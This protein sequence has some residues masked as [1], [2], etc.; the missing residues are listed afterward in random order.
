MAESNNRTTLIAG[1]FVLCGVVLL[2]GLIMEYGPLQHWMRKPYSVHAVFSDAQGLIKGAPVRLRGS[3]IGKVSTAP[4]L[5]SGLKGVQVSLDIYPEFKIPRNSQLKITTVGL[6]GDC[7]VDVVPPPP[8]KLTGEF[9][10][11]G[12]TLDGVGSTDLTAVATK[13]TD[14]ATEVMKDI[15][16]SLAE[17]NK[18]I[19]RIN[20]GVLSDANFKH[21]SDSLASLNRIIEK[22]ETTV[23][24][25]E[26]VAAVRDSLAA[27]KTT[28]QNA[29]ASSA[30]VRTAAEKIDKAMDQIGPGMKGFAGATAALHD[31][32]NALEAL[33]KEARSGRGLLYAL[34]NDSYLRD[35]LQRL[36]ANLRQRGILFYKDKEPPAAVAPAPVPAKRSPA[37]SSR[38]R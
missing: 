9:I 33:L 14:E 29:S 31:A 18:T 22:F 8:D 6:M 23:L 4:E 32:S 17:L 16:T 26:N 7:A 1:I 27:L 24:T 37:S 3:P 34:L 19:S 20:E 28:M 12:E 10:E 11:K 2:G 15:R 25:A 35:N 36:V 38:K 13:V 5:A 21:M 30:N